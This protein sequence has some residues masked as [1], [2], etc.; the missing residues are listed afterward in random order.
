MHCLFLLSLLTAADYGA[1][2]P[3]TF[4]FNAAQ[5]RMCTAI[6]IVDDT[7]VE[8]DVD[9]TFTLL[10]SPNNVPANLAVQLAPAVT[11]VAIDDNDSRLLLT[12]YLLTT[13][14]CY[15]L[16]KHGLRYQKWFCECD[17]L[18][19]HDYLCCR[20]YDFS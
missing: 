17:L 4:T 5:T 2:N 7:L 6:A 9:E 10:L 15:R 12:N 19:Q 16:V 18:P 20:W 3:N 1:P 8:G 13:A 11:T 14:N